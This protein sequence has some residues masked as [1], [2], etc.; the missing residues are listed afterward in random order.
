MSISFMLAVGEFKDDN[1]RGWSY[2][3]A[4]AKFQSRHRRSVHRGF[5]NFK[6][7]YFVNKIA[8]K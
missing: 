3:R 6:T 8:I 2:N 7:P 4:E 5:N 1:R